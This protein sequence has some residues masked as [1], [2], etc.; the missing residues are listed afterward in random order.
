MEKISSQIETKIKVAVLLFS[1]LFTGSAGWA[2]FTYS[3]CQDKPNNGQLKRMVYIK[4]DDWKPNPRTILGIP[5]DARGYLFWQVVNRNYYLG[6]DQRPYRVN[7][8][9]FIKNYADLTLQEQSDKKIMDTTE[10]IRNTNLATYVSMLGGNGDM[11]YNL[12]FKRK[13]SEIFDAMD[14]LVNNMKIEAPTAFEACINSEYFRN[15]LEYLEITKDRIEGVHESFV[16]RGVRL[17]A[18]LEIY[19]ELSEK[20][21]VASQYMAGQVR[22]SKIPSPARLKEIKAVPIIANDKKIVTHILSTFKF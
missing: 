2:Q 20:Y 12:F 19:K 4:W 3:I 16:D 11:P 6:E 15:F 8:G 10:K 1:F 17:E 13:F 5:L 18:Y 9:P 21:N 22:L 7:G 14:E